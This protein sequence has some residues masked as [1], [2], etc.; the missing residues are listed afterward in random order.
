MLYGRIKTHA[1]I[2][3]KPHAEGVVLPVR[4][5]PGASRSGVR[6]EHRGGLKV[7]VTQIAEKGKANAAIVE[8]LADALALKRSQIELISGEGHR[9]KQF[10][11]RGVAL[12]D[13]AERLAQW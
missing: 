5:M 9:D 10:L 7:A 2:E 6:G 12:A 11:I 3:L 4:A 13:L 8:V 1:M